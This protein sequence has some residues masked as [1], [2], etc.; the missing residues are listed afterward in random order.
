MDIIIYIATH[1]KTNLPSNKIY[2]PIQVG[3]N[4]IKEDFGYLKDNIGDNISNK[5]K[6]YCELTALYWIWKNSNAEIVGLVHY[7]RYFFKGMLKKNLKNVLNEQY[8]LKTLNNYDCILPK[9]TYIAKYTLEEQYSKLHNINDLKMCEKIMLEKYPDYEVALKNVMSKKSFYAFNM[10]I[11]P[12]KLLNRYLEWLFDILFELETRIK[13]TNYNSYNSRVYGF[14]SERL[15]NV[16]LE[17]NNIK[18]KEEQVY[19][20]EENVIK[21]D[22]TS[23]IK[24]IYCKGR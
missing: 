3:A 21:Q 19:N 20:I 10:F 8:I 6:N 1:K 7:R 4:D 15:F 16:W 2:K 11:M 22:I 14:L 5:N 24:R 13:I 12:K 17:K 23:L 9:K 18:I